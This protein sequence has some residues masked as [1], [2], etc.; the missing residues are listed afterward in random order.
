MFICVVSG[1]TIV[2]IVRPD[3]TSGTL[4]QVNLPSALVIPFIVSELASTGLTKQMLP[5]NKAF[6]LSLDDVNVLA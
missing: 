6:P 5:A 4:S 1:N 2:G 3:G